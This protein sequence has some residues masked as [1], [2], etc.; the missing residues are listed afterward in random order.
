[1]NRTEAAKLLSKNFAFTIFS[2]WANT[3]IE[4]GLDFNAF[5]ALAKKECL[6]WGKIDE[7]LGILD[8]D[9]SFS[10]I[11]KERLFDF[12]N[13][14]I[15]TTITLEETDDSHVRA[16]V[17]AKF[18]Q[19]NAREFPNTPNVNSIQP[20]V[21][22]L[23]LFFSS[24]HDS[25]QIPAF[26]KKF[27]LENSRGEAF[28]QYF[29]LTNGSSTI[30]DALRQKGIQ[31]RVAI[32]Y[33]S[34]MIKTDKNHDVASNSISR[35][36]ALTEHCEKTINEKIDEF[37][38]FNEE[39]KDKTQNFYDA[40][41]QSYE[42][43][44]ARTEENASVFQ[45][46][47]DKWG[48]E[49]ERRLDEL[50]AAYQTKLQL[51]APEAFWKEKAQEKKNSVRIWTLITTVTSA[52]L[53]LLG[54][55]LLQKFYS[56]EFDTQS[57][58][59]K[60]L[61]QSFIFVALISFLVYVLRIFIKILMSS[62]HMQVEYEQRAAFTRFYLS[63]LQEGKT[64]SDSDRALIYSTLFARVDPGLIKN[65]DSSSNE[66]EAVLLSLISKDKNP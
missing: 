45:E 21:L 18:H 22:R 37:A 26:Y 4:K 58:I 47:I 3:A 48:H 55:F 5:H 12:A 8:E 54:F 19:S 32:F 34:Q 62:K 57:Q 60:F 63:L 10:K 29:A 49:K 6:F 38:L 44:V 14:L 56:N 11:I 50:E 64:I 13:D 1:M 33:L 66:L 40:I 51:E 27:I 59:F 7:T 23:P 9:Y 42:K 36:E 53:I 39:Y 35:I 65:A 30:G 41:V 46:S 20:V 16:A 31:E 15:D 17:R 43:H 52:A 24:M 28:R 2:T 25:M 61:P